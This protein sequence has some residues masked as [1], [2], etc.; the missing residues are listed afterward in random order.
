MK[1]I[2]ILLAV[3][4]GGVYVARNYL[5][6]PLGLKPI[7]PTVFFETEGDANSI[8]IDF[9]ACDPEKGTVNGEFGA[10]YIEVWNQDV[11]MCNFYYTYSAGK[12]PI[13]CHVPRTLG[14]RTYQRFSEGIDFSQLDAYCRS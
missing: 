10:V 4:A 11:D 9:G 8:A 2:L 14:R 3:I 5:S 1:W 13:Q 6:K 7:L 12:T